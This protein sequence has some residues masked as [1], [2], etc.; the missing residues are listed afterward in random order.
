MSTV[1]RNRRAREVELPGRA[2]M[3]P[4]SS[5]ADEAQQR[6]QRHTSKPPGE[7]SA[8][9]RHGHST[10]GGSTQLLVDL[11]AQ[12]SPLKSARNNGGRKIA[13]MDEGRARETKLLRKIWIGT[14]EKGGHPRSK[15]RLFFP[16][17]NNIGEVQKV[18]AEKELSRHATTSSERPPRS[19]KSR[20]HLCNA[21]PSSRV[22]GGTHQQRRLEVT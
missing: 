11:P 15:S 16:P 19:T 4:G 2:T 10:V 21:K 1:V 13:A 22:A 5:N 18:A 14:A 9:P 8:A 3:A 7:L 17:P 6:D 20:T 12:K